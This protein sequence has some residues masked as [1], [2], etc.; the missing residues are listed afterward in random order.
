VDGPVNYRVFR[1]G[2]AIGTKSPLL[3]FADQPAPGASYTYKVKSIDS[4]GVSSAFSPSITVEVPTTTSVGTDTTPPSTPTGL[5]AVSLTSR[6][7]SLTWL[8]STD[9]QPGTIS[10]RVFRDS[11]LIATVTDPSFVDT[12][13]T[14]GT[15]TYT[16]KAVDAAG[17]KSSFSTAVKGYAFD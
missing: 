2:T 15:Y 11:A 10:Y 1:N 14:V 12:P 8:P 3:S 7:I 4:T 16:I 9:D 5:T 13:T 6:Q 17:N